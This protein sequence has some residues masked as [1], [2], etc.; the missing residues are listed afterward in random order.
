MKILITGAKGYIGSR[1]KIFLEKNYIKNK[2]TIVTKNNNITTKA[3]WE[4]MPKVD[5]VIHLASK[6]NIG[7]S[8]HNTAK[9][10]NNNII[11]TIRVLEY[12]K[13]NKAKVIFFSSY[14]YIGKKNKKSNETDSLKYNNP[15]AL[16]KKILKNGV[17]FILKILI[18][19]FVF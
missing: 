18:L 13:K 8:W 12:C 5:L 3:Y 14:L 17:V 15:Y 7:D 10:I 4:N 6:S 2:I 9:Y 11:G 1:L 16:T 19:I